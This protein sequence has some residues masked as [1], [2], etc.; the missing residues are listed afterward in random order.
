MMINMNIDIKI[1]YL[2]NDDVDGDVTIDDVDDVVSVID[3]N[4]DS[5][6]IAIILYFHSLILL[7]FFEQNYQH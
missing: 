5:V 4:N 7:K 2:I 3:D 1:T 6:S